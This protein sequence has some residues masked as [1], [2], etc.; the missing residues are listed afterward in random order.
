MI[1]KDDILEAIEI[2]LGDQLSRES[3][4]ARAVDDKL[5]KPFANRI[6]RVLAELPGHVSVQE[7]LDAL[8]DGG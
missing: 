4:K 5:V 1:D 2:A 8:D 3:F 7:I 6:R